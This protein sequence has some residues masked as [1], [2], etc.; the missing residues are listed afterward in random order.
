MI[1]FFFVKIIPNWFLKL[2]VCMINA[3]NS[4]VPCSEHF[5]S[6]TTICRVFPFCRNHVMRWHFTQRREWIL[7]VSEF[8]PY[9]TKLSLLSQ[10]C[11][12]SNL[13]FCYFFHTLL[14]SDCIVVAIFSVIELIF[15]YS[16]QFSNNMS[17]LIPWVLVR[18]EIPY[19]EHRSLVCKNGVHWFQMNS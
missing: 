16:Q 4:C 12:S 19:P 3:F 7:H 8:A 17:S 6:G 1:S 2:T 13:V 10:W 9:P 14:I 11:I 15:P 18:H 5:A